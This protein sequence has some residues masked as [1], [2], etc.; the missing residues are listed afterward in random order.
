[1]ANAFIAYSSVFAIS[2]CCA[3]PDNHAGDL[4]WRITATPGENQ[5]NRE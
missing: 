1:M 5:R 4:G 3:G 2:Q